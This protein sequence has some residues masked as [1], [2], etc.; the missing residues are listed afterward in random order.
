[1][2]YG[3]KRGIRTP[4]EYGISDLFGLGLAGAA[5][6]IAAVITDYRSQGEASAIYTINEW[7]VA[8]STMLG[9]GDIPLY[10]VVL[11]LIT[12]GA[13][14][15]F[16]FQPLTRQGA[17]AQG[18]GLLA[19]MMTAIPGDLAGA[20][21]PMEASLEELA[22]PPS[23]ASKTANPAGPTQAAFTDGQVR[24]TKT[25]SVKQEAARYEVTLMIEFEGGIP[26]DVADLIRRGK[27]RGRLHNADTDRTFNLFRNG[28]AVIRQKGETLIVRAGVPARSDE[29]TLWIRI[30]CEGHKIEQQSNTARLR[31]PLEWT[32]TLEQSSTPMFLQRLGQSYWF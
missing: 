5:G 2:P 15:V 28:G 6:I 32:V 21:Q 9:L 3:V 8:V 19:V 20:L 16:Y 1:M 26:G 29:A 22:P 14:S 12:I 24:A 27:L 11:G 7:T 31:T 30:E 25:A 10:V 17:F 13:G 18:F 4:G 23:S